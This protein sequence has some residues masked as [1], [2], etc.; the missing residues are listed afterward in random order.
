MN[1]QSQS[2]SKT[3]AMVYTLQHA[4]TTQDNYQQTLSPQASHGLTTQPD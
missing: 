1:S 2:K 3:L 4:Y